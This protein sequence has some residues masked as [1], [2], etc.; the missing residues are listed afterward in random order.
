MNPKLSI[1]IVNWNGS[2]DTIECI[3]SLFLSEEKEFNL[4]IVDN[5]SS[6]ED[7]TNLFNYCKEKF[8]NNNCLAGNEVKVKRIDNLN[9][10]NHVVTII[11]NEENLGFAIANNIGIEFSLKNGA[12]KILLLNNDTLVTPKFLKILND[13]SDRNPEYVALTPVI[14]FADSPDIIWNCGGKITWFG[15]RR[16]HYAG[17]S[18]SK[19]PD[20][21]YS[22]ITFITGC[23]LFLKPLETG[24]LSEKF[25]FGE[26]DFELSLRLAR[27]E[28]KIACVYD[29]LIFH[30]VGSS[31]KRHTE[32]S[33]NG[34]FLQYVSR[35]IDHKSY[36]STIF[37]WLIFLINSSYGLYLTTLKYKV[38]IRKSLRLWYLAGCYS[39]K[40]NGI[41]KND[42][43]NI[44]HLSF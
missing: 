12:D 17:K 2:N 7:Y 18:L 44:M 15:N 21:E 13:F 16:Y 30:K 4:I 8:L 40:L 19:L 29:S 36:Y 39:C 42:F 14:C 23:A 37:R 25:F 24:K 6:S 20:K 26:E 22:E 31:I 32:V 43:E 35:F 1:I 27:G 11:E 10:A 33:L 41:N 28:K 5:G 3:E 34:L 38:G 9:F